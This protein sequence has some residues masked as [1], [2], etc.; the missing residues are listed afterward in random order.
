MKTA[1]IGLGLIGGSMAIDLRK[2]GVAGRVSGVDNNAAHGQR[3]L[4]LGL[5]DDIE[6]LESAVAGADLV[7]TA[8]PV[9]AIKT[10]VLKVL[11]TISAGAVVVDTGSTKSMICKAIEN[12]PR[13]SQFVA[14]HPLAGT[15]NSGPD[16]ALSG[17]FSQKTNI[18]CER[19]RSSTHALDV[20]ERIFSTLEMRTIFMNPVEH[21][22]HVAYVSHLS[23]VSAFLLGQTVLD[24]EKDEKNIFNLAGS[25]FASTVRLAKSSP[26]M[27]APIFEQNAEYLSQ[28]L[29]EYIMH[30]QKFQYHLMKRD[31]KELHR[32]MTNANHIRKV[33]EGL[34]VKQ[35]PNQLVENKS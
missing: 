34:D 3:A 31:V 2:T 33:L 7:I 14:A 27:W 23:H 9:N 30:L 17:L 8:I 11:D 29:L 15:E 24:M 6:E 20:A 21:D 19:D 1:I 12:H 22:K 10:V 18:I 4:E 32:I 13:R 5:V 26:D 35:K 25:G 28:A 16:A